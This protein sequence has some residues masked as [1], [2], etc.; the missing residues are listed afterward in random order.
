MRLLGISICI[1]A[2][3]ANALGQTPGDAARGKALF[4]GSKANCLS[5]HRVNGNG[6]K[7]G[8]DLSD[9]GVPRP[10]G[11]VGPGLGGTA[12]GNPKNLEAAMLDPDAEIAIAN[13]SVRVVMKDG[14]AVTGRLMN[15]DNFTVQMLDSQGKLRSFIKSDLRESA[16]LA[17]SPMPSYKGKLTDQEVA[18]LVAYLVTLKGAGK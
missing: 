2:F 18:D 1:A 6:S 12:A 15:Q 8:P 10:A 17:K 4:E 11:G 3:F 9:I 13:R 14:T 16:V 5:C 7:V